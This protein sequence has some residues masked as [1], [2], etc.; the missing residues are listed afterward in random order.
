MTVTTMPLVRML[1]AATL[2]AVLLG[3]LGVEWSVKVMAA[4]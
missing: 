1:M 3:L 4:R 2:V